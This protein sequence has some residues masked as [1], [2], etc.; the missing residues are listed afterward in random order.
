MPRNSGCTAPMA[1][2]P[3]RTSIY[4]A[5]RFS[6]DAPRSPALWALRTLL[7]GEAKP[8]LDRRRVAAPSSTQPA[9]PSP[10]RSVAKPVR[11]RWPAPSHTRVDRPTAPS[12]PALCPPGCA[13][14]RKKGAAG[15][16]VAGVVMSQQQSWSEALCPSIFSSLSL[17]SLTLTCKQEFADLCVWLYA[18]H[19]SR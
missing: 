1:T 16:V 5:M 18:T 7:T 14:A 13:E 15:V 4:T 19:S 10:R 2:T 12:D 6:S 8:A 11:Q 9:S 17:S 3:T